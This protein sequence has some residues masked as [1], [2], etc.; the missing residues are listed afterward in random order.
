MG[1]NER[2]WERQIQ[3]KRMMDN[4]RISRREKKGEFEKER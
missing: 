3:Q 2:K 4:E 1:E